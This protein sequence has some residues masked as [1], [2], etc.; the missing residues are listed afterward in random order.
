MWPGPQV[1]GPPPSYPWQAGLW[2][3]RMKDAD[4]SIG[5]SAK[6]L[7]GRAGHT[8]SRMVPPPTLFCAAIL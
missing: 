8:L 6:R 5:D 1:G 2:F 4:W 7:E 3:S